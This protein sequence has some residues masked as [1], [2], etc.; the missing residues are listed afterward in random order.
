[1]YAVSVSTTRHSGT[2]CPFDAVVV[3]E[4]QGAL[5]SFKEMLRP[6]TPSFPASVL[7]DLHRSGRYD[8]IEEVLERRTGLH[9]EPA[10]AGSALRPGQIYLAPAD[11]QLVIS[12]ERRFRSSA[13]AVA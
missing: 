6:L 10:R 3:V 12:G 2:R 7:F 1:V 4:S 9:V 11:R 8:V 13:A 5:D